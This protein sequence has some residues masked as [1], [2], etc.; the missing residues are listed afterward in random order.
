MWTSE[1]VCL[2]ILGVGNVEKCVLKVEFECVN[3]YVTLTERI[4]QTNR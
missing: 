2:Y 3:D 4:F 1:I